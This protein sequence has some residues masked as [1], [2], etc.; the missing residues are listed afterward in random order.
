MTREEIYSTIYTHEEIYRPPQEEGCACLEVALGCSWGK[1]LFCDFA[2]DK[3]QIHPMA[4]IEWNLRMLGRLE[5]D[6]TRLFL[7][8]ENAFV[9][10]C[11]QLKEII[12]MTHTFMPNIKEFSMYARI[13]DV[14]RKTP[15]QL[16][17]LRELGVCDLHIGVESG[18]DPILLWMNKGVTS[19]DMLK[20]FKMLDEAGI[21]YYVTII[22]GLG[23]KN[24]P[25]PA[26]HR[27]SPLAQP[28]S[29]QVYL[30]A[31]AEGLGG[32]AAGKDDRARRV[33]PAGQGGNPV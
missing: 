9:M 24:Y 17:E 28:H 33:C 10:S 18:S 30:G 5:P 12:S 16:R 15:E 19:F 31:E 8:G 27:D 22:L 23:G 13:D 2:K 3:F 7:L 29:P 6:K 25:K 1:C 4:K 26:R 11:E 20:A 21:G 32:H 14:L